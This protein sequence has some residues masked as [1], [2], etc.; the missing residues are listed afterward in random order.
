M[1]V[2][3]MILCVFAAALFMFGAAPSFDPSLYRYLAPIEVT[4]TGYVSLTIPPAVY[5][6]ANPNLSDLRISDGLTEVPYVVW[7]NTRKSERKKIETRILN[8]SYIPRS[9]T[10]FTLDVGDTGIGTNNITVTTPS[11]DFVRRT[12]VEGSPDNKKFA[13]LKNSDYIFDLTSNRNLKNL[14]ISY[15]TTDYRYIR[16]T[17]WDDGEEPLVEVGGEIYFFEDIKGESQVVP[18]T[19]SISQMNT[20]KHVTE[21]TLDLS[22]RNVPSSA[23]TL[24]LSDTNFNRDVVIL[25]ANIDK[26]EEYTEIYAT[27][28]YSIQTQR[29]SRSNTTIEYPETQARYLKIVIENGS[30]A[31]LSITGSTVYG[32]P[33]KITFSSD[34]T[35]DKTFQLYVGNPRIASPSY[36]IARVFPYIDKG[37]FVPVSLG[38]I[39]ENPDYVAG[40]DL[41]ITER[42]PWILWGAIGVMLLVLGAI[43]I[44]MMVRVAGEPKA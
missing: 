12:T 32:V 26:P 20:D 11:V 37:T 29:F 3:N 14:T 2:R 16:V 25:S 42:Y 4:G 19:M 39:V 15:P 8:T 10:T 6:K 31:P 18:S 13:V 21:L 28:I 41:P 40:S 38:T 9:Y 23:V 30:D 24:S 22:S 33:R 35:S 17:I 44:R 27:S 7:S 43:I 5:D 1:T 36:D 34:S